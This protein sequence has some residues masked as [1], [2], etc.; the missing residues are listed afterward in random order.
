MPTATILYLLESPGSANGGLSIEL[1]RKLRL[2]LSERGFDVVARDR[3]TSLKNMADMVDLVVTIATSTIQAATHAANQFSQNRPSL[4]FTLEDNKGNSQVVHR[5]CLQV[6]SCVESAKVIP[7]WGSLLGGAPL[8]VSEFYDSMAPTYDKFMARDDE[9]PGQLSVINSLGGSEFLD[10][11]CG[12]GRMV[13]AISCTK[14]RIVGIDISEGMLS[15]ARRRGCADLLRASATSLPFPD[16]AFDTIFSLR[17]GWSYLYSA[18]CRKQAMMEIYRCLRPGGFLLWD[19]PH[20]G[21][22]EHADMW[23]PSM[24][25]IIRTS[26]TYL[27]RG[28][29]IELLV[30]S[31][32][33]VKEVLSKFNLSSRWSPCS[34][35]LIVVAQKPTD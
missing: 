2:V 16:E 28:E 4:L 15:E 34:S 7:E 19:S 23:W 6:H 20:K 18:G 1:V 3:S 29:T 11:G 26:I 5:F 25:G 21:R 13:R 30:T 17:M 8:L 32:F 27:S 10:I 33:E 9:H 14:R 22:T 31:G 24:R 35:R 12:T